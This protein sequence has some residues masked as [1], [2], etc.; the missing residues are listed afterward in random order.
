MQHFL[1]LDR[2]RIV[3]MT[4]VIA[5]LLLA[6]NACTGESPEQALRALNHLIRL[7]PIDYRPHHLAGIILTDNEKFAEAATEFRLGLSKAPPAGVRRAM[8]QELAQASMSLRDFQGALDALSGVN[9]SPATDTQRAE[10]FW[11]LG[12]TQQA[13]HLVDE[14][15]IITGEPPEADTFCS[16]S[17]G[18]MS[19]PVWVDHVGSAGTRRR[20][21]NLHR[22]RRPAVTDIPMISPP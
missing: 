2:L 17:D 21:G 16:A 9:P 4:A 15:S 10:C 6:I 11:S 5:M 13:T 22:C 19:L 8:Q 3:A 12:D 18:R 1:V 14:V 7:A 20:V